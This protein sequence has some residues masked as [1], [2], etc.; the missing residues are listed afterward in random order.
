MY[1]ENW[2]IVNLSHSKVCLVC[3]G[4]YNVHAKMLNINK[5]LQSMSNP[6]LKPFYLIKTADNMR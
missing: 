1:G 3:V 5:I 4:R 2:N 6:V